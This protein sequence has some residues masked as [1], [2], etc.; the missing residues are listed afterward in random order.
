MRGWLPRWLIGTPPTIVDVGPA[1]AASLASLHAASFRRGWTEAEFERLLVDRNVL[2]QKAVVGR[3]LVGFILSRRAAADA[4]ILSVAVA[5]SDRGRGVAG[6]L[7]DVHLRNLAGLGTATVFLEVEDDNPPA[8]RLYAGRGFQQVGERR[9]YYVRPDG[10]A[11]TA[12][13]LRRDLA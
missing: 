1:A 4:E 9:G 5:R 3:K 12:L 13:I 6:A 2:A 8:R 10:R 11:S 7:L